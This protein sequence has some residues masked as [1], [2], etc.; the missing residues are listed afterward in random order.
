[1]ALI[2]ALHQAGIAVILDWVPGA[3]PDRRARPRLL[4]RHA[5][6]RAPRSRLGFHPEWNTSI[7]D[8]G[9]AGG[10]QLPAVER[11]VLA[12]AVSHRRPA[13]RR[14][15]VDALS[16]LR[17]QARRVDPERARAAT[18]TS[19]RS[20]CCSGSTR[21]S[22]AS[23][24]A[25][26]R[27]P[28]SRPRGRRSPAGPAR[29]GSASRTSGTWAGCTTRCA[30]LARDPVH[31]R[32]HHNELTFR[33][34]Y[35]WTRAV[36]A[37]ALARRGRLR[38]GLAAR[39]D[40]RRPLAEVREPAPALRVHVVAAGQEAAVHGRRARAVGAS[41]TTTPASTGTCSTMPAHRQIQLLVGEL[42]RL[43]RTEPRAPRARLRAA[44]AST[45]ST[46]DDAERS[47]LVYERIA[48]DD[49]RI[50]VA[51][52]FTPVPRLNYRVGVAAP[53]ILT[54]CSTP[55]RPSSAAG[56]TATSAPWKRLPRDRR[57]RTFGL[58][59]APST[60][61]VFLRWRR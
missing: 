22:R 38:Q 35:A 24:P 34:V 33:G 6:L 53:G 28:R 57:A 18:S 5:A 49:E 51:L 29:A 27:S 45:G 61:G 54:S 14:R 42:N 16:R 10:P 2:D 44:P 36:R 40:A 60:A 31:R 23:S 4:R 25:R 1:M 15:R 21:R 12:R 43:Y 32:H 7:F 3:L 50:I 39:Q 20:S 56:A 9:R 41:G 26:S 13:R 47:V 30:Y 8:F 48:R 55:T 46:A 17:P 58:A 11:A 59:D 19:R 52:N 37:A